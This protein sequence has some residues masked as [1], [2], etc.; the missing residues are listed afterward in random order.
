MRRSGYILHRTIGRVWNVALNS[1]LDEICMRMTNETLPFVI[2]THLEL[3]GSTELDAGNNNKTCEQLMQRLGMH[4]LLQPQG[5]FERDR[6]TC[7]PFLSRQLFYSIASLW[8][9]SMTLIKN[10]VNMKDGL[11]LNS[12]MFDTFISNLTIIACSMSYCYGAWTAKQAVH[13]DPAAPWNLEFCY[14]KADIGIE[15]WR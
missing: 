7:V 8:L 4:Q 12:V 9:D 1:I 6:T 15:F 3:F 5:S 14:K 11:I 13:T 2:M 10:D